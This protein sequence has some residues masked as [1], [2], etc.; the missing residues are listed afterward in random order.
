MRG[1]SARG[2]PTRHDSRVDDEYVEAVLSLV[3][4]IPSGRVMAYGAVA[5]VVGESLARGGPRLVGAVMASYG[6]AV[7]WWRVVTASGRL[8]LATRPPHCGSWPQRAVR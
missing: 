8:R 2:D 3:E 1:Q 6:G 5:E 7:P 4:R